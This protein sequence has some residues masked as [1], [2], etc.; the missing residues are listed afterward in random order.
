MARRTRRHV[1]LAPNRRKY[2]D[3]DDRQRDNRPM[4]RGR[5]L[6]RRIRGVLVTLAVIGIALGESATCV[7][8][9]PMTTTQMA[10]CI[11]MGH[12]CGAAGQEH[13]CCTAVAH[14]AQ[15]FATVKAAPPQTPTTWTV[16]WA[17]TKALAVGA[18]R[19][20]PRALEL[21]G[22]GHRARAV[23]TYLRLS[24]LLI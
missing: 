22:P 19:I 17:P 7:T 1:E 18:A 21:T 24:A 2:L 12:D 15:Y 23:P 10:C 4:R 13:D 6:V 5:W 11:A 8:D 3:G 14:S 20:Q 9:T 16:A